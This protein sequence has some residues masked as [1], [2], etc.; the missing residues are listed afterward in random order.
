MTIDK[1]QRNVS[2]PFPI[3]TSQQPTHYTLQAVSISDTMDPKPASRMATLLRYTSRGN[4]FFFAAFVGGYALNGYFKNEAAKK[5]PL[6]R[7]PGS[8]EEARK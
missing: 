2:L 3:H 6:A 4:I 7:E 1:H 5:I 8:E